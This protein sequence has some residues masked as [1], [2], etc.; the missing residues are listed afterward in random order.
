MMDVDYFK[1]IN[2]S[3][4][5]PEGDRAL[6]AVADALRSAVEPI[7]PRPVLGRYGGDEFCI[8]AELAGENA[9]E[10]LIQRIEDAVALE[11]RK[12]NR[13]YSLSLS[14]GWARWEEGLLPIEFLNAA[15]ESLYKVKKQHHTMRQ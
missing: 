15:D 9:R 5:H 8:L 14:I 4:G 6:V 10:D 3:C 12:E 13:Q 2:D 7:L 1:Q 11:N